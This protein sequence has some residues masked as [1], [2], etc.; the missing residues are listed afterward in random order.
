LNIVEKIILSMVQF[1]LSNKSAR[2]FVFIYSLLLHGLV[3]P[4]FD[5]SNLKPTL[6][7]F[8][9]LKVFI[10]LMNQ[11]LSESHRRDLASSAEWQQKYLDHMDQEHSHG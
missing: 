4:F 7:L 2:I 9:F 6:R 1:M 8:N 3:S 10:V 5:T 11:A